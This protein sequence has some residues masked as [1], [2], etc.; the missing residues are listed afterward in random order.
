[1]TREVNW[2]KSEVSQVFPPGA[3]F[4]VGNGPT[5]VVVQWGIHDDGNTRRNAPLVIIIDPDVVARWNSEGPRERDRIAARVRDV[6][7]SG[8]MGYDPAGPLAV[9]QAHEI[10]VDEGDL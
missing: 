3:E 7:Q 2:I 9:P 10:F 5:H 1:M 8:L 6:I 4:R